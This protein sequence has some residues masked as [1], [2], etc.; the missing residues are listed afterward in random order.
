MNFFNF[1]LFFI[2]FALTA[3]ISAIDMHINN[4]W[5]NHLQ[6]YPAFL[7]L[8]FIY[9]PYT[10]LR[11]WLIGFSLFIYGLIFA[12]P[13]FL[14]FVL[15]LLLSGISK[16]ID[17]FFQ[18]RTFFYLFTISI[19]VNTSLFIIT[20]IVPW[21]NSWLGWEYLSWGLKFH[22]FGDLLAVIIFSLLLVFI[23]YPIF[24]FLD[25][26]KKLFALK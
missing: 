3:V 8:L 5:G 23:N 26:S 10:D 18:T 4:I 14:I 1:G 13:V 7:I 9:G 12:Y 22:E 19:L 17:N 16:L 20:K 21:A 2:I 15:F 6:F 24:N 25:K 11:Y